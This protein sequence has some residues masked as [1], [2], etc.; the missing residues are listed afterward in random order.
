MPIIDVQNLEKSFRSYKRREGVFGSVKDLFHRDYFTV[1]AVSGISL[2]VEE[3]ELLGY[4]GPNG[5]GKS[6][7]IKMLTGILKPTSG[8]MSV[9]GYH[10]FQQ[11]KIYTQKIGVVFG[12]RTQLWW[13][14]AVL[15]SFKL[16]AK[17]YRV[18]EKDFRARLAELT[19]VL[20]LGELL[21]TPV[22]KL[23]LGQRMRCDLA[24]SLLHAPKLLFLDEPTIG[25]DAVAK[26]SIRRFLRHI[27]EQ[28]RTTII[29]TTHDLKEIEELCERIVVLDKGKIVYDGSLRAIRALPGLNRHFQIEFLKEAPLERLQ[30]ELGS[31]VEVEQ[32]SSRIVKGTY[33]PKEIA[34]GDLLK[35]ILANFE[36][37]DLNITEPNIEE[38]IMKIYRE[39]AQLP[40]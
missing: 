19:P 8:E 33:D 12:Q 21:H 27:N 2:R 14:I 25:L 5:A 3:G 16:L 37:V 13:D 26:D 15:E 17:I 18:S 36:I 31:K 39:G 4:I 9:M 40:A 6:T 29:L 1:T 23:S 10:P 20:E 30:A 38:V 7:S 35:S 34:T 11:R 22:R 24:A 28:F 32:D